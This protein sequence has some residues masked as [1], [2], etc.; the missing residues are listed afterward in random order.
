M[1]YR[2]GVFKK[3]LRKKANKPLFHQVLIWALVAK[4]TAVSNCSA[5]KSMITKM[6]W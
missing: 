2:K 6:A 1:E 5:Y 4:A 3:N